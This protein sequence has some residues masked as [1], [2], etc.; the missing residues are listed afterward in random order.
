MEHGSL[1][2]MSDTKLRV[3]S[4][5]KYR[6]RPKAKETS[7]IIK[8]ETSRQVLLPQSCCRSAEHKRW[9]WLMAVIAKP[10]RAPKPFTVMLPSARGERG[11]VEE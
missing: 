10:S 2:C 3:D 6:V 11:G 5:Q 1:Q 7:E 4:T 8:D 9:N